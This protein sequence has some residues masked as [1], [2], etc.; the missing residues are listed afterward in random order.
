MMQA[1]SKTASGS[2]VL[3]SFNRHLDDSFD[4]A[5]FAGALG[6][7][8]VLRL[9]GT[10]LTTLPEA[11]FAALP[12]LVEVQ[13]AGSA[14]NCCGLEYL[15][16]QAAPAGPVQDLV[17]VFCDRPANVHRTAY[18]EVQRSLS[19]IFAAGTT[20]AV[21]TTDAPDK[22][23]VMSQDDSLTTATSIT[24]QWSP[25]DGNAYDVDYYQLEYRTVEEE[26]DGSVAAGGY[27]PWTTAQCPTGETKAYNKYV[28][29]HKKPTA[30][31]FD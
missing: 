4:P 31:G 6:T 29:L 3:L 7:V 15:Q 17:S 9:S 27:G 12:G 16:N 25:V 30:V 26:A 19:T 1:P 13:L 18:G 21:C 8:Q 23:G 28:M 20:I 2:R 24:G 10:S 14:W 11:V 22:V 5:A